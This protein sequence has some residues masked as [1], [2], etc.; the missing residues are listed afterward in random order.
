MNIKRLLHAL[1]IGAGALVIC[2]LI[3]AAKEQ[4]NITEINDLKTF[5]AFIHDHPLVLVEFY[6]PTCPVCMAFKK[7]GI[8]AH[9]AQ[10]L[11]QV[12]YVMVSSHEGEPLHFKYGI[13]QFPTFVYFKNGEPIPYKNEKGDMTYRHPGYVDEPHFTQRARAIFE[14]ASK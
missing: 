4:D 2:T 8:F 13:N 7:K 12:K 14:N 10:Q 3:Y 5:D 1:G 11:P 6:N 9:S